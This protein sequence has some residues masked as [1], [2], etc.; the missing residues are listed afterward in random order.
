VLPLLAQPDGNVTY[1]IDFDPNRDVTLLDENE[2]GQS[3]LFV[4]VRFGISVEGSAPADATSLVKVV[5]E[6]NDHRVYEAD[7]PRPRPIEEV[8]IVLAMDVSGSM[9]EAGRM[10]KARE[11]SLVFV[12]RLPAKA[13]CGLILFNHM[14]LEPLLPP[15]RERAA[16]RKRLETVK[17]S[18][19]T[20][21]LDAAGH[22][23][24]MLAKLP[25]TKA[26][27]VVLMTDGVDLNSERTLASVIK[28]ANANRTRII[29]IGIGEPGKQ[30]PVS[31]VLALD[32]SGSMQATAD[33]QDKKS[34]IAA[35]HTAGSRFIA[36][37]PTTASAS[38]LP[39]STTVGVP[40]DFT[41]NR[42][43]LIQQVRSLKAEGETA[44]L[45]ATY[46]AIGTLEASNRP[47]KR[48]VIVMTDGIDN[49]SRR[50][51]DEVL[52]RAKEAKIP[53]YM[54][55]FGREGEIDRKTMERLARE[56]G[57]RFYHAHNEASL[58]EIFENLSIQ[59][60]DDGVDE[61]S[62]RKLAQETGGQ[63][64]AVADV[65]RLKFALEQISESIQKKSYEVTFPS[66]LQKRDGTRRVVGIKL[67]R[68]SGE[69][70][71]NT[72]SGV[73]QYGTEQVLETK[74]TGYQTRGL[75]LAEMH[76]FVYVL[77]LIGLGLL[78]MLPSM[79]G[80]FSGARRG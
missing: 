69:V 51:V 13:D 32:Q 49:S 27:Y 2:Q 18:G 67:V 8:G 60:H 7:V 47:G 58:L 6:E 70:A 71:S 64:Y 52:A 31:T 75:V 4:K 35:L 53:L 17:P 46:T 25:P 37:M 15:T 20:A 66:L 30:E 38:I 74:E 50:R 68:R 42:G 22:A 23:I 73:V 26:R 65:G 55:G 80:I 59:L 12:D 21:Y 11:A 77:L 45:D 34:K 43:A 72:A 3:G 9:T 29:T 56:T 16:L 19:G 39:F 44:L 40:G 62:L 5:I 14:M 36:I 78:M 79:T 10:K 57:G 24:E 28:A 76:P 33:N 48:A 1:K 61:I 41:N 54:L 63:Y